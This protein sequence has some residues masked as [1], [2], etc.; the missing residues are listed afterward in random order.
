MRVLSEARV[1]RRSILPS[2]KAA[3]SCCRISRNASAAPNSSAR[4]VAISAPVTTSFTRFSLVGLDEL[5]YRFQQTVGYHFRIH[6]EAAVADG[7]IAFNGLQLGGQGAQVNIIGRRRGVRID[8]GVFV[9]ALLA[10]ADGDTR[11]G[12]DRV[13]YLQGKFPY[14]GPG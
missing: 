1:S 11:H 5:S 14:F 6:L 13:I 4:Q 2:T 8:A 7:M 12:F 10:V 3:C 9:G